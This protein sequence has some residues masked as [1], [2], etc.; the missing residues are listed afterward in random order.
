MRNGE[1]VNWRNE[2]NWWNGKWYC[3]LMMMLLLLFLFSLLP[4][5][6]NALVCLFKKYFIFCMHLAFIH[7]LSAM[8]RTCVTIFHCDDFVI[9]I[10]FIVSTC[11]VFIHICLVLFIATHHFENIKPFFSS[12]KFA[13]IFVIQYDNVILVWT[14]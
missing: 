1:H 9:R 13:F 3:L 2:E 10:T 6:F 8:M 4:S 11:S 12:R 14:S 5:I 7:I